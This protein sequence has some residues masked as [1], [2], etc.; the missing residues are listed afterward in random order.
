MFTYEQ[1]YIP[2]NYI[3]L[4]NGSFCLFPYSNFAI[5]IAPTAH[6]QKDNRREKE[7]E[8]ERRA[9]TL[10]K[11]LGLASY[12]RKQPSPRATLDCSPSQ[13]ENTTGKEAA[14][15]PGKDVRRNAAKFISKSVT[16]LNTPGT[17]E[18]LQYGCT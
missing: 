15:V 4:S 6:C 7:R 5:A 10:P 1:K 9:K 3:I 17:F 11:L 16:N 13:K 14:A 12:K 2:I 8:E 18:C